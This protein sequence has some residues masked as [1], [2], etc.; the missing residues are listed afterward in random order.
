MVPWIEEEQM[1]Q[2]FGTKNC[3]N[4]RK[5]E[6]F[7]KER[8]KE[9]QFRDLGIKGLAPRELESLVRKQPLESLIDTASK[10]Y[11]KRGL[12]Y[13]DF[14]MEEELLAHPELLKTPLVRKG[15]QWFVG[16]DESGWKELC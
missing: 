15:D 10:E 9:Y 5:A 13:M 8:N 1:I 3:K 2:V 11:G 16:I 7:F 14:D 4:T 6:R 12:K